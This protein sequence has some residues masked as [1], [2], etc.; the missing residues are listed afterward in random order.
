MT[1]GTYEQWRHCIE[2]QCGIRLT[3]DYVE[4]RLSALRD[5]RDYQ[6]QRFQEMW[7]E[8]HLRQV[9]NWFERAREELESGISPSNRA[10][11]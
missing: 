9:I 2:V 1:P 7:G 3:S 8:P 4:Q 10:R 6:T 5:S 11:A